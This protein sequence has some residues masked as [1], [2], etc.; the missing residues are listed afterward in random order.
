MST[1]DGRA[2]T[3]ATG[4]TTSMPATFR[5]SAARRPGGCNNPP[6][7]LLPVLSIREDPD[8]H[9]FCCR[10]VGGGLGRTGH[11][12]TTGAQ[13]RSQGQGGR[14]GRESGMDRQGR[15]VP[16]LQVDGSGRRRV[17]QDADGGR[18]GDT[19]RGGCPVRRPGTV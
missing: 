8:A 17:S 5:S 13:R 1:R 10:P 3:T 15:P 12:E 7:E 2:S 11:G 4:T 16:A 6:L 18:Q 14:G 9:F 19:G